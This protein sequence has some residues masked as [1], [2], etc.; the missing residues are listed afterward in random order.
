MPPEEGRQRRGRKTVNT[1]K[2][3]KIIG[4]PEQIADDLFLSMVVRI[5]I[6]YNC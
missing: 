2:L 4:G 5:R 3:L 6:R 1:N